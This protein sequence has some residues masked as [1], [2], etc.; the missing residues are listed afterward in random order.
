MSSNLFTPSLR[1]TN[2]ETCNSAWTFID[3]QNVSDIEVPKFIKNLFTSFDDSRYGKMGKDLIEGVGCDVSGVTQPTNGQFG[4]KCTGEAGTSISEGESCDLTCDTGYTLSNQPICSS[5]GSGALSSTSATCTD[6]NGCAN[7]PDCGH[8]ASCLDVAAPG[9]GYTC[10]CNTDFIGTEVHNGPT[11]CAAAGGGNTSCDISE[12]SQPENGRFGTKCNGNG[13]INHGESCDL[14]CNSGYTLSGEQASCN[15]GVIGASTITCVLNSPTP[16]CSNTGGDDNNVPF[17]CP[18]GRSYNSS[19]ANR[20]LGGIYDSTN[21]DQINMCCQAI[22]DTPTCESAFEGAPTDQ[23][24]HPCNVN[25]PGWEGLG[26]WTINQI[27]ADPPWYKP[28]DGGNI[29]SDTVDAFQNAIQH[30]ANDANKNNPPDNT[31]ISQTTWT[32]CCEPKRDCGEDWNSVT[33][34]D[35]ISWTSYMSSF[36]CIFSESETPGDN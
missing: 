21:A 12:I 5:D 4:T 35:E 3:G 15:N 33:F 2:K 20:E 17:H 28:N 1:Y 29:D 7:N 11:N 6:T 25:S 32:Q 13:T 10:S 26:G 9:T 31:D 22:E 8:D 27:E 16:T 18:Q 34:N 30:N 24:K 14:G 23:S 19:A 36:G